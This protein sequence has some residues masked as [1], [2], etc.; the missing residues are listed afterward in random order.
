MIDNL[1][2]EQPFGLLCSSSLLSLALDP[3]IEL[4]IERAFAHLYCVPA[5]LLIEFIT[6]EVWNSLTEN[7]N[8][9]A[10]YKEA[11]QKDQLAEGKSRW[12][13]AI[14]LYEMCIFIALL[15]YIG[16]VGTSNISSFWDKHGN[17]IHKPMELMTYYRF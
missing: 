16:I 2:K 14:T 15:I 10:Q 8:A 1:L 7:T 6:P 9:Y 3:S 5:P 4:P 13:K 12:W 17:T 11:R